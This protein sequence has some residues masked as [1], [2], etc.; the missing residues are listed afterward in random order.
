MGHRKG[1]PR[2]DQ[3]PQLEP[4]ELASFV[5]AAYERSKM[6]RC[7]M[8]DP[9]AVAE[10]YN[11][12]I[13]SCIQ[14]NSRPGVAGLASAYGYDRKHLL[15]MKDGEIKSIPADVCDTLKRIWSM[16]EDLM[17]QYS[18][19][20]KINPVTSIFMFKNNFNYKDQSESVIIKKDPYE[21]GDPEEIA[22]RYL[23]GVAPALPES[24]QV[25]Q[26][27]PVVETVVVDRTGTVE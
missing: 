27:A 16:F 7:D 26:D 20:G 18:I 17:E 14:N 5:R 21:S 19:T 15:R 3:V 25:A 10:R 6:P 23:A 24:C 1:D 4:D 22:R 11:W 2:P 13:E 9:D 8:K 12:Y